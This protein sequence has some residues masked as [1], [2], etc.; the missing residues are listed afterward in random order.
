MAQ[1]YF[2]L[3][4]FGVRYFMGQYTDSDTIPA[5][6]SVMDEIKSV[7]SCTLGG[8]TKEVARYRTLNGSGWESVAPLGQTSDDGEFECI[9][10]GT[11]GI[12][13]G[14]AGESTFSKVKTWFFDATKS[15]GATAAKVIIEVV[16]RGDDQ[17]EATAYMC[18]PNNFAPAAKDTESGQTYNFTVTPFGPQIPLKATYSATD[19][20]FTFSKVDQAPAA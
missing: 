18:I 7:I 3:S 20:K 9:R 12:W 8:F 2:L 14:K 19:D 15:G 13:E 17:Y 10:E 6:S 11:G 4:N 5:D 1:E 16:P